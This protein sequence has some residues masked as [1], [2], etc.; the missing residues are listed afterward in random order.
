MYIIVISTSAI[1][2]ADEINE[3]VIALTI[4]ETTNTA[5][6]AMTNALNMVTAK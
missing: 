5:N 4:I 3:A 6:T 1:N 2:N